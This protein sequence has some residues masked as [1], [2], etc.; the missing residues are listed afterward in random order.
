MEANYTIAGAS[1][2]ETNSGFLHE[3]I[4]VDIADI[5]YLIDPEI[6]GDDAYPFTIKNEGIGVLDTAKLYKMKFLT[7]TCVFSETQSLINEGQ[8]FALNINWD[9]PKN[10]ADILNFVWTNSHKRW[11]ALMKDT[12]GICYV[13]G[14]LDNGLFLTIGRS[15]NAQ[16]MITMQL[17]GKNWHPTWLLE[18]FDALGFSDAQ[19]SSAFSFDFKS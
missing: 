9:F 17:S 6:E 18:T 10:K 16:N 4:L 11:L 8:A 15:I 12:N 1:G 3:L 13:A 2:S 19:F 7:K 5:V 14:D